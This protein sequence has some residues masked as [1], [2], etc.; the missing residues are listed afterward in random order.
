V[1]KDRRAARELWL[2]PLRDVIALGIWIAS[3]CGDRI[4]WRGTEYI[5]EKGKLRPA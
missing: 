1:L 5:L 4:V 3:F 2:L